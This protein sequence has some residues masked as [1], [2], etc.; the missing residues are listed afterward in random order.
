MHF[1]DFHGGAAM[2][3]MTTRR[4]CEPRASSAGP[5]RHFHGPL[6]VTITQAE[7]NLGCLRWAKNEQTRGSRCGVTMVRSSNLHLQF[8]CPVS[9]PQHVWPRVIWQFCPAS[10]SSKFGTAKPL[11]KSKW[12]EDGWINKNNC[13]NNFSFGKAYIVTLLLFLNLVFFF[14][15]PLHSVSAP[16]LC[17]RVLK[18]D[19][20]PSCSLTAT[21]CTDSMRRG[22][23]TKLTLPLNCIVGVSFSA[24]TP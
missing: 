18:S 8:K 10:M 9:Q 15:V 21:Q 2:I 6:P 11:W 5:R 12:N 19:W 4:R 14:F 7:K 16:L 22:G 23:R 1:S 24:E 13:L 3:Y 20:W 17:W